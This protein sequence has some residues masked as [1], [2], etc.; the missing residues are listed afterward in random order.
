MSLHRNAQRSLSAVGWHWGAA[1]TAF[2]FPPP[3]DP[4]ERRQSALPVRVARM[5]S[6]VCSKQR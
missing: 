2:W 1:L 5:I 6:E 3:K 4:H